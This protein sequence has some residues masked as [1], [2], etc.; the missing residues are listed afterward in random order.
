MLDSCKFILIFLLVCV[1]AY[2]LHPLQLKS[3]VY[4][5]IYIYIYIH[6]IYIY[7]YIYLYIYIHM[8]YI[9]IYIYIYT[10]HT[11]IYVLVLL[12]EKKECSK[13][14]SQSV[15]AHNNIIKT[16]NLMKALYPVILNGN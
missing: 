14:Y 3:C 15:T 16:K 5:Y 1:F 13:K 11:Y 9:Y 6:M 8:I 10:I 12:S 7:I 2:P 4:A